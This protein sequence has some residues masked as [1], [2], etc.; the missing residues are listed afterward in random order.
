MLYFIEKTV[1]NMLYYFVRILI[2]VSDDVN[3]YLYTFTYINIKESLSFSTP[4][5]CAKKMTK[6]VRVVTNMYQKKN[7]T[8]TWDSI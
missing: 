8:A 4:I 1:R 6:P 2:V 3:K 7:N 5:C